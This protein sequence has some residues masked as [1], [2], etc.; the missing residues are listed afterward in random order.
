[1]P[2]ARGIKEPFCKDNPNYI[3]YIVCKYA[4]FF[5]MAHSPRHHLDGCMAGSICCGTKE[6]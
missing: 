4:M 2:S 1:M 6:Y 5:G 3:L